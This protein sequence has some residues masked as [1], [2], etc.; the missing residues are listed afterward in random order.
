M[1][2][3]MTFMSVPFFFPPCSS[4]LSFRLPV[5]I[6]G[7][8]IYLPRPA[9]SFRFFLRVFCGPIRSFPDPWILVPRALL[10][11][12]A[13]NAHPALCM[14]PFVEK[15][16]LTSKVLDDTSTSTRCSFRG[17]ISRT[18]LAKRRLS[19]LVSIIHSLGEDFLPFNSKIALGSSFFYDKQCR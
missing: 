11:A 18:T 10:R 19:V 6:V 12:F 5:P 15:S 1:S 2:R 3:G 14:C 8:R 13:R 4:P 9:F 17:R 16:L 7:P